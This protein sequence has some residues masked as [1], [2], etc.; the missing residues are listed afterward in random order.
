MEHSLSPFLETDRLLFRKHTMADMD[1]YCGMEMDADVR[2]YVGGQPRTRQ[3]AEKRFMGTLA[4]SNGSLGMWA[5]ILKSENKYIGR[6]GIY[7]HV[8][9]EGN[10]IPGE[11]A[12]GLYIA[13]AYWGKGLATEAAKAF[14]QLGFCQLKLNKIVAAVQAGN[15]ASVRV[16]DKLGFKLHDTEIGQWRTFYHFALKREVQ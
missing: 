3:E 9:S 2:R 13:K 16:M 10:P 4:P 14:I 11:A 1:A 15:D 8:D 7:Q 6:C 5:T 12:L